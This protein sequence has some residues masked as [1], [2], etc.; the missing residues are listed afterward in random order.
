MVRRLRLTKSV[1]FRWNVRFVLPCLVLTAFFLHAQRLISRFLP[2][3]ASSQRQNHA[4]SLQQARYWRDLHEILISNRPRCSKQPDPVLPRAPDVLFDPEEHPARPDILWMSSADIELMS[5][6]HLKFLSEIESQSTPP[7]K[8]NTKGIVFSSTELNLPALAVSI[9]ML[10]ETNSTLPIEVFQPTST[11]YTKLFCLKILSGLNARCRHFDE[12]FMTAGT[13]LKLDPAQYQAFAVLFSSFE[14]VLF[15]DNT[16]P[17]SSPEYLFDSPSFKRSGMIIWPDIWFP[18]ESP[19]YFEIAGLTVLEMTQRPAAS[20]GVLAISKRTHA[21][22]LSLAMYYNY[23]GLDYY[24][25]LQRQGSVGPQKETFPLAAMAAREEI[26]FVKQASQAIGMSGNENSLLILYD[27]ENSIWDKRVSRDR[28]KPLFVQAYT[29]DPYTIMDE[30]SLASNEKAKRRRMWVSHRQAMDMFGLD[31][32]H[33][34]WQALQEVV[35]EGLSRIS[36]AGRAD[37]AR[38]ACFKVKAYTK[39]VF[40]DN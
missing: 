29:I 28:G 7:Y 40:N 13:P 10:R 32:E 20:H 18:S 23:Y 3:S 36:I 9:H 30:G 24:Y 12:L 21:G 2:T 14:D 31:L 4:L 11:P 34:F 16:W 22:T 5:I 25:S 6:S 39:A 19:Y 26:H 37:R 17:I 15:V 8:P 38:V 1:S 33:R 27:V 35:C